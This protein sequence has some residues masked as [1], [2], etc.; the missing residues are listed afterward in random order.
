L[1]CSPC[2][3][4]LTPHCNGPGPV[5]KS[6]NT[7]PHPW[8]GAW[9]QF[10]TWYHQPRFRFPVSC[11]TAARGILSPAQPP[12]ASS[13]LQPPAPAAG[14]S[15]SSPLRRPRLSLLSPATVAG[16]QPTP[17][18]LSHLAS[19]GRRSP[20]ADRRAPSS[21]VHALSA[22]HLSQAAPSISGV[23]THRLRA[24]PVRTSRRRLSSAG[25][26]SSPA[27]RAPSSPAEEA[28][29]G[30]H[31][32]GQS[33]TQGTLTLQGE[34]GGALTLPRGHHINLDRSEGVAECGV[35]TGGC[36]EGRK[37][38]WRASTVGRGRDV[39]DGP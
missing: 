31:L 21:P 1:G 34:G 38:R 7:T 10:P 2:N 20:A 36:R 23:P 19:D 33:G 3:Y 17:A 14:T 32:G 16:P 26:L 25:R 37:P 5:T 4:R 39:A 22:S 11:P 6:I 12:G 29:R 27:G 24:R 28:L 9:V 8:L 15:P 35:G 18:P 13:P 30:G